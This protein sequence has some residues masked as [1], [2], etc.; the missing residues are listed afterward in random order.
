[1]LNTSAI[2]SNATNWPNVFGSFTSHVFSVVNHRIRGWPPSTRTWQGWGWSL[3]PVWCNSNIF[4]GG[5][6]EPTIQYDSIILNMHCESLWSLVL[7]WKHMLRCWLY[8][9]LLG[10]VS[11]NPQ[12]YVGEHPNLC[13]WNL[14][15]LLT[16]LFGRTTDLLRGK[17]PHCKRESEGRAEG[18][19]RQTSSGWIHHPQLHRWHQQPPVT[20]DE[21]HKHWYCPID[22]GSVNGLWHDENHAHPDELCQVQPAK[23]CEHHLQCWWG[24]KCCGKTIFPYLPLN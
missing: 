17:R 23:W 3:Q 2:I 15:F 24:W 12:R 5:G 22:V 7:L 13:C 21:G 11:Q 14:Q 9:D 10:K 19:G 18:G 1:M 8:S 4:V 16:A 6:Q 20:C